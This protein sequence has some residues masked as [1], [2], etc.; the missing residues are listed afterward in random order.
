MIT[1]NNLKEVFDNLSKSDIDYCFHKHI[2]IN[3]D[4]ICLSVSVFNAGWFSSLD[5]ISNEDIENQENQGNLVCDKDDLLRL[6]QES[7]SI[8]PFLLELI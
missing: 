8:N 4:M 7:K 5:I 1:Q 6:F 2:V 3:E